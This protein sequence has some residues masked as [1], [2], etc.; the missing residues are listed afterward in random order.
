MADPL[1]VL[2]GVAG[3]L[4]CFLAVAAVL[5]SRPDLTA[6]LAHLGA[7]PAPE[8]PPSLAGAE[9]RLGGWEYA[10]GRW[11]VRRLLR[12]AGG[13]RVPAAD[14]EILGRPV[15]GFLAQKLAMFVLGLA[16]PAALFALLGVLGLLVPITL[17]VAVALVFAGVLFFAPDLVV[18]AAG[19]EA[20]AEFRH[21]VAAYLNLVA[22][23]RAADGDRQSHSN[24]PPTSPAAGRSRGS[25]RR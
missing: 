12:P 9:Q 11:L 7:A 2:A 8:P 4:G 10:A 6:A 14:L 22:L 15:E 16:L 24:A 1:A 18:R 19:R 23:E 3:G 5:P 25:P 20:R 13:L 21:A 17:P